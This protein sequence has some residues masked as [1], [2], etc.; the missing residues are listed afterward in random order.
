[1]AHDLAGLPGVNLTFD[2][3]DLTRRLPEADAS[4]DMTL[5]LYSVLSHLPVARLPEVSAEIAAGD[6]KVFHHHGALSR[7]H[8]NDLRRFD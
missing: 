1:M 2:V 3:A 7:Q 8:S 6:Q 5:C 4:V